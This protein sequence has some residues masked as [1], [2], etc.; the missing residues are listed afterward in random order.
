MSSKLS[1]IT[2]SD[3]INFITEVKQRAKGHIESPILETLL[4]FKK[5]YQEKPEREFLDGYKYRYESDGTGKAK[6]VAFSIEI[7]KT[8]VSK[9]ARRPNIVQKFISENGRG[10]EHIMI[11]I[12]ENTDGGNQRITQQD[13]ADM[14]NSDDIKYFLPERRNIF[15]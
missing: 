12:K 7:P 3:A 2:E 11:L 13:V 14:L 8:W 6:D 4:I 10:F 15:K 5:G 9:E 1:L